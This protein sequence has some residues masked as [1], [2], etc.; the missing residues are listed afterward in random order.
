MNF[1]NFFCI[2]MVS[3]WVGMI[4]SVG[5]LF[6]FLS[7][8]C[9]IGNKKVVVLLVFVFVILMILCLVNI[10]L[11]DWNWML[12]V[13]VY[14]SLERFLWMVVCNGSVL[15]I[16]ELLSCGV[17]FF[18]VYLDWWISIL[19]VIDGMVFLYFFLC[20]FVLVFGFFCLLLGVFFLILVCIEFNLRD[21]LEEK[22]RCW[23]LW[24]Y[25]MNG[26]NLDLFNFFEKLL[27]VILEMS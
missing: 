6:V 3:L 23:F 16:W 27:L 21:V 15:N 8:C 24:L 20:C 2:C 1:L 25:K 22:K 10:F 7:I 18:V 26:G 12:V 11:N 5:L 14:F 9:K 17:D 4:I 13:W 19:G